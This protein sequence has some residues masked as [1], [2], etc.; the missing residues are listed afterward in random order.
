MVPLAA[1]TTFGPGNTAL[2]VNHQGPFVA[3]TISFN[4]AP[5][6]SLSDA[7]VAVERAMREIRMPASI[8]GSFAGHRA[9]L[10]GFAGQRT[11]PDRNGVDR[12]LHRAGRAV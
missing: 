2:A 10:P 9:D 11:D 12:H 6:Q 1:F 3:S 4:L 7:T 5:G 8:H